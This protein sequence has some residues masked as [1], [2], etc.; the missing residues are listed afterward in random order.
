MHIAMAGLVMHNLYLVRMPLQGCTREVDNED[1]DH[2]HIPGTW[3]A[4]L[5]DRQG[6]TPIFS[7]NA[8][9]DA[10]AMRN[11]LRDYYTSD[12]GA[13]PW[14]ERLVFPHGRP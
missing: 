10:K 12:A 5:N 9:R 11:Y 7:R 3:R 2:H 8:G 6:L 1:D 14:Q 4:N 13:V